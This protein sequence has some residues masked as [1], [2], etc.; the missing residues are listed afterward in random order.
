MCRYYYQN[1]KNYKFI[2][3]ALYSSGPLYFM[4]DSPPPHV[5]SKGTNNRFQNNVLQDNKKLHHLHN[6]VYCGYVCT[7]A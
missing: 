1:F 2:S 4:S 7:S 3:T 6:S 5:G